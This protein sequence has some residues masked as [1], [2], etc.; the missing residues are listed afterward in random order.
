MYTVNKCRF[1]S[2]INGKKRPTF[3]EVDMQRISYLNFKKKMVLGT[4]MDR[5]EIAILAPIIYC[6]ED[7]F[8]VAC[9]KYCDTG[10]ET[11]LN[12]GEYSTSLLKETMNVSYIE[13]IV[14]LHNMKTLPQEACFIYSPLLV[15]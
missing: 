15:E 14:I 12:H 6:F 7:N 5:R 10:E 1:Y 13:A 8:F 3:A 2:I 9:E 11:E 4:Q